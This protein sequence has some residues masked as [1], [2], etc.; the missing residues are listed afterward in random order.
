MGRGID[1]RA[2]V[3]LAVDLDQRRAERAQ[4]LHA[5]RL[6][7]D[8]GAGAPVGELRAPQDQLVVGLDAV[9]GGQRA[10]RMV[11]R[12]L[13][14]GRHLP[15]LGAVAHQR[16]VAARAER[17]REGIEQD[18]LAG[19]GLAG[20]HGQPVGEIDV[21]PIDQDDV[22]DRKPGK[23]GLGRSHYPRPGRGTPSCRFAIIKDDNEPGQGPA[24][25]NVRKSRWLI[26]V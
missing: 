18:R 9:V 10:D 4:R 6:V 16:G 20:E 7:V 24:I 23:H 14:G 3:V 8:E 13:E 21:E 12:Q 5:H 1:Q 22:A 17:Q 25:A 11:A 26:R 19:A 15:L 2:V